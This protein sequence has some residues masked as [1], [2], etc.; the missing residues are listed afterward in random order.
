MPRSTA[1]APPSPDLALINSRWNSASPPSTAIISRPVLVLGV[2]PWLGQRPNLR[3]D[4]HDALG[5]GEQVEDRAGKAVDAG[6]DH[7]LPRCQL[8][9]KTQQFAAVGLR[10][11]RRL[12]VDLSAALGLQLIKPGVERLTVGTDA[13]MA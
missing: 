1:W 4:V 5:E 12:P 8:F 7:H 9:P 2:R 11:A 3:P 6:G 10:A 13:G